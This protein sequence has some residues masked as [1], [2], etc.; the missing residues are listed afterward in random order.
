MS[1]KL[2]RFKFNPRSSPQLYELPIPYTRLAVRK[3]S[4]GLQKPWEQ[5]ST[6]RNTRPSVPITKRG[7]TWLSTSDTPDSFKAPSECLST[8]RDE[9]NV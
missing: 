2:H 4:A 9:V 6:L 7:T 5:D 8:H 3:E 1:L